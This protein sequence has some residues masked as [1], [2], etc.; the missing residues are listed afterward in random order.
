MTEF[1]LGNIRNQAIININIDDVIYPIIVEEQEFNGALK[2]IEQMSEDYIESICDLD[3]VPYSVQEAI[4]N[5]LHQKGF[6]AE[7]CQSYVLINLKK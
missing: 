3:L 7:Y 4:I 2:L 5:E 1:F 6:K